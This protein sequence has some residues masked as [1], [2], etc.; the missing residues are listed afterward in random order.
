MYQSF[1]L[2]FTKKI[3]HTRIR[4]TVNRLTDSETITMVPYQTKIVQ[5]N[6]ITMT[7]NRFNA[8]DYPLTYYGI[9]TT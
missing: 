2:Q 1:T 3:A 6:C 8:T 4:H 9:H 7:I 5:S